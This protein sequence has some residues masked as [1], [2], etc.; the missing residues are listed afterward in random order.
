MS[1]IE[2]IRP[3]P[4]SVPELARIC[5][6]AFKGIHQRH[7]FPLD[8]PNLE[9]ARHIIGMLAS[10]KDFFSVAARVEGKLVGSN[11]I[12]IADPVGGVGPITLTRHL[13]DAA[14]VAR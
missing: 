9:I 7:G 4:Q 6:E 14:S 5:F 1:N 10:R 11:F 13:M 3:E 12:S 8:I 2:L